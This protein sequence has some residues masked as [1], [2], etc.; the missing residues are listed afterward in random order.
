MSK[1]RSIHFW[2][3]W[4]GY[5]SGI[6]SAAGIFKTDAEISHSNGPAP[7]SRE[8]QASS[9]ASLEVGFDD[10]V[11]HFCVCSPSPLMKKLPLQQ[12]SMM[13]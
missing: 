8:L 5:H 9:H 4:C 10:L 2:M 3:L 7:S 12:G 11:V 6:L 1:Q 13:E